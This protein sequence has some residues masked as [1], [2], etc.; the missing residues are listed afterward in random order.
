M[1][2]ILK[3]SGA[4]SLQ[5]DVLVFAAFSGAELFSRRWPE[6]NDCVKEKK[7]L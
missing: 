6:E 3:G 2:G 1:C 5:R 4:G 7:V